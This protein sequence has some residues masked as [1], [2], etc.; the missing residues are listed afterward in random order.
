[1]EVKEDRWPVTTTVLDANSVG[2]NVINRK[3]LIS[4]INEASLPFGEWIPIDGGPDVVSPGASLKL[5]LTATNEDYPG[6]YLID[7]AYHHWCN[8]ILLHDGT[9]L[10]FSIKNSPK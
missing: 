4:F 7:W 3:P 9:F 5:S 10:M 2:N 1:V 6:L 8:G